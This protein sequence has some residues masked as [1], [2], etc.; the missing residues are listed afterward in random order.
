MAKGREPQAGLCQRPTG[1]TLR[2]DP[3]LDSRLH[4]GARG[5]D[6]PVWRGQPAPCSHEPCPRAAIKGQQLETNSYPS[7]TRNPPALGACWGLCFQGQPCTLQVSSTLTSAYTSL[8]PSPSIPTNGFLAPKEPPQALFPGGQHS[9]KPF[10]KAHKALG[11]GHFPDGDADHM[12]CTHMGQ[13]RQEH[14]GPSHTLGS[15]EGPGRG[16]CQQ[17]SH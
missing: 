11:I 6:E 1:S 16:V 17:Q 12:A 8:S 14:K 10:W 7:I 5:T 4:A 9:A 15:A 13:C 3:G 2:K